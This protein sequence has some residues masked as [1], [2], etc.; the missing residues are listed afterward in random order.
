MLRKAITQATAQALRAHSR[1]RLPAGHLRE[2]LRALYGV[3]QKYWHVEPDAAT[4]LQLLRAKGCRLGIISNAPDDDDV[5]A[6][7][8]NAQL[9]VFFDFVLTSAKA[10]VRKPNPSIFEAAL[11]YWGARPEQVVMVGDTVTADVA[12]ANRLR[13]ASV[14]ILRRA[15]TPENHAA[16]KMHRP[17]A[18]IQALS[19]LPSLLE[20][21]P[22]NR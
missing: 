6:L 15:D 12:G 14:W 2:A 19:E 7:V 17:D 8:E 1:P 4:T 10:K 9:K 18:T 5:Q 11:A 3:T 16:V 21:W 20:D 22:A 13:I